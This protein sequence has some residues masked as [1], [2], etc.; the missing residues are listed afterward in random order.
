MPWLTGL[1][2][3]ACLFHY[4]FW[5]RYLCPMGALLALGNKLALLQRLVQV[6]HELRLDGV[7][8]VGE[9]G[10]GGPC[11]RSIVASIYK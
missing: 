5:C 6:A 3:V 8:R 9:P 10:E 7:G 4:R 11:G 1:V 2:L